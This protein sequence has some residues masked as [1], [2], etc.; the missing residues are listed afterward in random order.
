MRAERTKALVT[1]TLKVTRAIDLKV[2]ASPTSR[3]SPNLGSEGFGSESAQP[4]ER[5]A[6]GRRNNDSVFQ[7][8]VSG[9]VVVRKRDLGLRQVDAEPFALRFL[10]T[11][12]DDYIAAPQRGPTTSR[13]RDEGFGSPLG[14]AEQTRPRSFRL[15]AREAVIRNIGDLHEG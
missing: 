13:V 7:N 4:P 14:Y 12:G 8:P 5:C 11:T 3:R 1:S 15:E 9:Y 6:R 2:T 10:R